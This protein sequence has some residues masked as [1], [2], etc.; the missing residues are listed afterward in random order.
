MSD[1]RKADMVRALFK[2]FLSQ[3]REIADRLLS[4]RFTFTSPYDDGIDKPPTSKDAGRTA[5]T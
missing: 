5:N 4:D 1:S 3:D 2:A